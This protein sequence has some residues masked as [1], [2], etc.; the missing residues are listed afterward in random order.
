MV[1]RTR[2]WQQLIEEDVGLPLP[3]R[4]DGLAAGERGGEGLGRKHQVEPG[5][6]AGGNLA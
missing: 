3:L 4:T 6:L 1:V 5:G 2:L